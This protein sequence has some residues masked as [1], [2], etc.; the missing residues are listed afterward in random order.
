[1]SGG[2]WSD[3]E[4][5]GLLWRR[6]ALRQTAAQVALIVGATRSAVCGALHRLD[7]AVVG[8]SGA[9]L[10]DRLTDGQL[11]ALLDEVQGRGTAADVAGRRL[12]LSRLQVLG[13]IHAVLMDLARSNGPAG[14]PRASHPGNRNGDLSLGWW[15]DGL[16][17]RAAA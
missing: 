5:L 14:A 4:L 16:A 15:A 10:A 9:D 6:D 8:T 17:R 13:V 7:Q 2:G 3:A 12:N 1:M 11:L